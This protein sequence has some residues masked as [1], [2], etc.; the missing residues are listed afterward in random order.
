[1]E[2]YMKTCLKHA[3]DLRESTLIMR[4]HLKEKVSEQLIVYRAGTDIHQ[5]D[6]FDGDTSVTESES[7]GD[8]SVTESESK[9]NVSDI[10]SQP[11]REWSHGK[12][13]ISRLYE[14][15]INEP[16]VLKDSIS[17]KMEDPKVMKNKVD[18]VNPT[19]TKGRKRRLSEDE[20]LGILTC[21]KSKVSVHMRIFTYKI[22]A[23][24]EENGYSHKDL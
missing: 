22:N 12:I 24:K 7:N 3:S 2:F 4:Q 8:I 6:D 10:E 5:K 16:A 9:G 14:G 20:N 1:M 11:D 21:K 15:L 19:C 17:N 23:F 13:D 18:A